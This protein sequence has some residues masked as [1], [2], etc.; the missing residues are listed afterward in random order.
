MDLNLTGD[1]VY[2]KLRLFPSEKCLKLGHDCF[3][4]HLAHAHTNA[5]RHDS[6]AHPEL[7]ETDAKH[8][9][10]PGQ[11]CGQSVSLETHNFTV[12]CAESNRALLTVCVG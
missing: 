2:P 10:T 3:L 6:A 9:A 11:D 12:C 1:I 8:A 4:W 7:H 5:R